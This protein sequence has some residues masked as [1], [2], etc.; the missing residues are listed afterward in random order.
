[1]KTPF[2]PEDIDT[3]NTSPLNMNNCRWA[4]AAQEKGSSY[5]SYSWILVV[6]LVCASQQHVYKIQSASFHSIPFRSADTFEAFESL[7]E[8]APKLKPFTEPF[9]TVV[10]FEVV[11]LSH[12][13][14]HG[15]S[16]PCSCFMPATFMCRLTLILSC[17]MNFK[18]YPHD[19]QQCAMKIESCK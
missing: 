13:S 8:R 10:D 18:M 16:A 12:Y 7:V 15:A 11:L 2:E 3:I 5:S 19:T 14:N 6:G 1:M 4:H 17:S 9:S